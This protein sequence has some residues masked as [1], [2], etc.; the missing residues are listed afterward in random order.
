MGGLFGKSQTIIQQVPAPTVSPEEAASAAIEAPPPAQA[1]TSVTGQNN[2][3]AA[4]AGGM[5]FG[6]TIGT[7]P[8]GYT[9]QVA[10]ATKTLLGQ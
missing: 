4:I 3:R 5:G 6:Q 10:T 1:P 7:S 8:Q 9:G 2:A